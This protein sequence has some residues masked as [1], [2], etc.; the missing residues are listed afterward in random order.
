MRV[1]SG[2]RIWNTRKPR[3]SLPSTAISFATSCVP[4]RS[5]TRIHRKVVRG[6]AATQWTVVS[7][8]TFMP[9]CP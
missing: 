5:T 4:S 2:D 7:N 3:R 6:S 1:P 8:T 9:E